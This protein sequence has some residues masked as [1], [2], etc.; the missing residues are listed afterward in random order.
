LALPT[1]KRLERAE[2][3]DPTALFA[4][5]DFLPRFDPRC[6]GSRNFHMATGANTVLHCDDR[7]IA[8][9]IEQALELVEHIG[10]DFRRKCFP[11]ICQFCLLRFQRF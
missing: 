3:Q 2:V 5:D 9:A 11:L 7:G 8:F 10:V 6:G 1:A 4:A